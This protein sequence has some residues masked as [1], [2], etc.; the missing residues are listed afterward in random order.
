MKELDFDELDRAVN[1]LITDVPDDKV[2]PGDDAPEKTLTLSSDIAVPD[3]IP[4]ASTPTPAP[5]QPATPVTSSAQPSSNVPMVPA[6]PGVPSV[7]VRRAGRFMDVVH[8][9]SDMKRPEAT[10]TPV[11]RQGVTITPTSTAS[12]PAEAPRPVTPLP[13]EQLKPVSAPEPTAPVAEWP[14]P[15]EVAKFKP[16]STPAPLT[17]P[18]LSGTKVEKRPLGGAPVQETIPEPDKSGIGQ[19]GLTANDANDQLPA[20]PTETPTPLPEEL[21]GDLVAIESGAAAQR[22]V[23]PSAQ[24]ETPKAPEEAPVKPPM[25]LPSAPEKAE[26]AA[27]VEKPGSVS[28][29]Q[30]YREEPSTGDSASGAIY[31]T[32]SYHQPLA[33]PAKKKSS[34]LWIVW[35]VLILLL[36]A[37]AGV[38]LYFFKII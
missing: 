8:P 26:P 11:S 5:T 23:L 24:P 20:T 7:A 33:H 35:I 17:T 13:T 25:P 30:Q 15:L 29:P 37:G 34:W 10:N 2:L 38:A 1:S 12:A 4:P 19:E 28:I 6:T 31:D 3:S 16:D 22:V 21:Q 27:A 36:G 18:F 32:A 9:S 14:D